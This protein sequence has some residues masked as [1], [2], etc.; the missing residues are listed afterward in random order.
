MRIP[1]HLLRETISVQDFAGSG[2]KGP[3]YS[4][5]RSLRAAMQPTSRLVTDA[6]GRTVTVDLVALVRPEAGPIPVE[7]RVV[8]NG[9]TYRVVQAVPYPDTR[10]PTQWELGLMR[11]AG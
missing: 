3:T 6:T 7:S 8:W 2:A 11:Y 5:T 10:R 1:N 9:A 4:T